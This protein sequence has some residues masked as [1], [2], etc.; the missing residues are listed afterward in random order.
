MSSYVYILNLQV[1]SLL[2]T[3]KENSLILD[4]ARTF[5]QDLKGLFQGWNVSNQNLKT[6]E[7]RIFVFWL[8]MKG[9]VQS[10]YIVQI[11]PAHTMNRVLATPGTIKFVSPCLEPPTQYDS[12]GILALRKIAFPPRYISVGSR[13]SIPFSLDS[14]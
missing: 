14:K 9:K 3:R 13:V 8:F 11:F 10:L 7:S 1:L 2:F 5:A 6:L 4:C 12:K